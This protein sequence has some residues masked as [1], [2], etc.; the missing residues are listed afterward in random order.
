MIRNNRRAIS[1]A[2]SVTAYA[3]SSWLIG[4]KLDDHG[5][6]SISNRHCHCAWI[7]GGASTATATTT[8]NTSNSNA[9]SS[10]VVAGSS[11]SASP[12][13]PIRIIHPNPNLEIAFD[14]RTRTPLYVMEKLN[15]ATLPKRGVGGPRRRPNF[16]EDKNIVQE[17]F[18]SKL[19]HYHKSGFDRGHM[20]PGADFP[21]DSTHDTYTL[22]NVAPQDPACNRGIWNVLEEWIRRLVHSDDIAVTS[23]VYVVTGPLW[24]PKRQVGDRKFEYQYLG[25]GRPPSLIMVPTHFFK[26]VVVVNEQDQTIPQFACFVVGNEDNCPSK[27]LEDYVVPWKD[28]ETVTGLQ[29]FPKWAKPEWKVHAD[30]VMKFQVPASVGNNASRIFLTDRSS[31]NPYKSKGKSIRINH[32]CAEGKCR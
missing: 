32:L 16:H 7:F 20:A 27:K 3:S 29:F 30:Q 17:E 15:K 5:D 2:A 12:V 11:S 26:V 28:L 18:R 23:T 13:L 8:D 31:K 21:A 1:I 24:L 22:C 6:H 14:V 10:S 25:L 4:P 9:S 19:S